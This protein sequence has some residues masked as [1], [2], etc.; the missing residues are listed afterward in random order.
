MADKYLLDCECAARHSVGTHQAGTELACE[1]GRTLSVPRLGE[2]RQLPREGG[3]TAGAAATS[4]W[5]AGHSLVMAGLTLGLLALAV[6][7]WAHFS[8]PSV[9]KY[10]DDMG[11]R[12]KWYLDEWL[13]QASPADIYHV[14]QHELDLLTTDGFKLMDSAGEKQVI[15]GEAQQGILRNASF[16]LAALCFGLA[17][18]GY[19]LTWQRR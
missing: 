2:L 7:L 17:V 18:V 3:A 9:S 11:E 15:A 8:M 6:G 5:E 4:R 16:V 10:R 14:W 1:C 12:S 19:F 13:A